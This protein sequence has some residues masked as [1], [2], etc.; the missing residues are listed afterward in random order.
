[1]RIQ[2]IVEVDVATWNSSESYESLAKTAVREGIQKLRSNQD[3]R[4]ISV[5]KVISVTHDIDWN[6]GQP[7]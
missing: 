7:E 2:A 5:T 1:M 4:V 3:V 6:K